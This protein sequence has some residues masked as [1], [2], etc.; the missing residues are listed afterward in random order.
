MKVNASEEALR[1]TPPPHRQ[2]ALDYLKDRVY[3][4][5]DFEETADTLEWAVTIFLIGLIFVNVVVAIL[6]TVQELN[7]FKT[8]FYWIEVISLAVFTVEY[9]LRAWSITVNSKYSDPF[10]GRLVY[11]LTPMALIDFIAIFPSYIAL[12]TGIA[13]ADFLFLRSVRLFRILRVF[14]LGRYHDSFS[15]VKS[16]FSARRGEFFAVFFVGV[17]VVVLTASVMYLLEGTDPNHQ[18]DS[19]PKVMWWSVE[20]LTTVGYGDMVPATA[21]GKML[22]AIIALTGVA[23]VALPAG[24]LGAGFVEEFQKRR[25]KTQQQSTEQPSH[26]VS[27]ADEIRKFALLRD[28]GLIT[29]DEFEEQKTWLLRRQQG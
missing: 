24:I 15:T 8:L 14:K 10:K 22:G 29:H 1:A 3:D 7:Q 4:I 17:V 26:G 18:F 28:D 27:V 9:V 13:A 21:A 2:Y 12:G 11:L 23:F 25:E 6:D 16:V 20:T 19:I 5:L